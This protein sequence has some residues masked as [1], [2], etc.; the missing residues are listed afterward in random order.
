MSAYM[1]ANFTVVRLDYAIV[2]SHGRPHQT[3][4]FTGH[5][6][7]KAA[8]AAAEKRRRE[9]NCVSVVDR[10]GHRVEWQSL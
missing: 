1:S 4:I 2:D 7:L 9:Y 10:D 5:R 3:H 6:T 8:A